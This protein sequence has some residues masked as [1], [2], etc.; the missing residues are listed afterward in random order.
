[1]PKLGMEHVSEVTEW[2]TTF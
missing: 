2:E 1:M